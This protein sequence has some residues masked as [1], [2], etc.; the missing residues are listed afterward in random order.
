MGGNARSR[1]TRNKN[2]ARLGVPKTILAK[3][4]IGKTY[5]CTSF[6][7]Y[8]LQLHLLYSGLS[9]TALSILKI[10]ETVYQL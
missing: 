9:T 6:S 1:C 2:S 8:D 10:T 3:N 4:I 7:P 5:E